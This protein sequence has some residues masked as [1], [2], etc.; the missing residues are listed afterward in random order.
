MEKFADRHQAGTILAKRLHE[1]ERKSNGIVLALPRGGVPVAYEIAQALSLP[2]DVFIVRK[3]GVPGHEE[4]AMGAIASGGT[5]FFNEDIVHSMDIPQR[6]IQAVIDSEQK[7][8]ARRE[9]LYRQGK[10]FPSLTGKTV[11]LVDDGIATGATIH[12]AIKAL[13]KLKPEQIILAVPV[14]ALST[15]RELA[16]EVEGIICPLQP[17]DF[18]AVGLW[19]DDFSQTTDEEVSQLLR[20][21]NSVRH[22][23]H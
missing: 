3:L 6:R 14:A 2:L 7:E 1:Y 10:P 19:Y 9:A 13:R 21:T 15:C 4:L 5:L 17:V 18:Y 22:S 12:A 8:L 11:I 20:K 16:R 23:V